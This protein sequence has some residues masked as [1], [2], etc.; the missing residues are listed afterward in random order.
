MVK[1]LKDQA[2][3]SQIFSKEQIFYILFLYTD[4]NKYLHTYKHF[5]THSYEYICTIANSKY[6]K[7]K[8][9]FTFATTV[10]IPNWHAVSM[11]F[12]YSCIHIYI[13]TYF[14]TDYIDMCMYLSYI[15]ARIHSYII[16]MCAGYVQFWSFICAFE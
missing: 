9:A 10:N 3:T 14:S 6:W 15:C 8:F 1:Q 13:Q 5:I 2:I 16:Y 4:V 7:Q 12:A 11:Y